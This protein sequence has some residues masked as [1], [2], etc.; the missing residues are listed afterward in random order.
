M[1]MERKDAEDRALEEVIWQPFNNWKGKERPDY[2]VN[3]PTWPQSGEN[4]HNGL[5]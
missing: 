5:L 4:R 1:N 3:I 2:T